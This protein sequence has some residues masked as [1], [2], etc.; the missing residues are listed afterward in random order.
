[1]SRFESLTPW[2]RTW[3]RGADFV[4]I[5]SFEWCFNRLSLAESRQFGRNVNPPIATLARGSKVGK[6]RTGWGSRSALTATNNS[7]APTSMPAASGCKIGNS[8]H[9][10][11][12]LFA[13]G[14][15]ELPVGCPRRESKAN[16]Q[17]RS[18][19][20]ADERHHTSVRKPRT[21]ASR[22]A[23]E[24]PV[25]ARAVA[26]IRQAP[27]IIALPLFLLHRVWQKRQL[28]ASQY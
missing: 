20:R 2:S 8:S 17:S 3:G 28:H 11:F 24:A 10:F 13:I 21:H 23:C 5:Q 7:L 25:S 1:M 9:R 26:V 18:S 16:S 15:S 6:L 19:V 4:S 12:D 22:R 27:I 14:S